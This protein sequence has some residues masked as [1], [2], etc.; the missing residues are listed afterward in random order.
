MSKEIEQSILCLKEAYLRLKKLEASNPNSVEKG[1][2]AIA[3]S[4]VEEALVAIS[5]E[6]NHLKTVDT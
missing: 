5:V 2:I 1:H 6:R 3:A 4:F